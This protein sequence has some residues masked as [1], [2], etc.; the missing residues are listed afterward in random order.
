MQHKFLCTYEQKNTKRSAP[1]STL[2][3]PTNTVRP[4]RGP[5]RGGVT[6]ATRQDHSQRPTEPGLGAACKPDAGGRC[7]ASYQVDI[8]AT[9]RG[10][11]SRAAALAAAR[12]P[13]RSYRWVV[14]TGAARRRCP[15]PRRA[16]RPRRSAACHAVTHRRRPR[17]RRLGRLRARLRASETRGAQQAREREQRN[18]SHPPLNAR[19]TVVWARRPGRRRGPGRR[20]GCQ[21]RTFQIRCTN[22]ADLEDKIPTSYTTAGLGPLPY[23]AMSPRT[24]PSIPGARERA[25]E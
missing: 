23:S 19:W 22:R 14:V 11:L 13:R 24:R 21:S 9:R 16:S 12:S 17:A 10:T 2:P 4:P 5:R 1:S 3:L 6:S 7:S 25:L 15:R 8:H 18:R 20:G